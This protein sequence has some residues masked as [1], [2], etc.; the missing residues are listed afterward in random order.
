VAK[1]LYRIERQDGSG[2]VLTRWLTE[3]EARRM[4]GL[5]YRTSE[6][7]R[8]MPTRRYDGSNWLVVKSAEAMEA[9]EK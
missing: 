8:L 6:R 3:G 4:T 1:R 2:G 9:R 5:G 7:N